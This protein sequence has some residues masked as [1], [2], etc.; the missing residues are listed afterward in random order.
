MIERTLLGLA[1]MMIAFGCDSSDA[2][3]CTQACDLIED[4]CMSTSSDCVE[5]CSADLDLCPDEMGAVLACVL[6]SELECDPEEDQ[7]LAKAPC[8]EEHDAA[9]LCGSDP[10]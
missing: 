4:A 8:E 5:D 7:G 9:E 3:I 10:F 6:T 1:L 2:S